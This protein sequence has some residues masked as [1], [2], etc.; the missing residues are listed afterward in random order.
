[1]LNT[2]SPQGCVLSPL[3][4]QLFTHDCSA[5]M[6]SSKLIKFADDITAIGMIINDDESD[7]R[8]EIELLVKWNNDN[9]IILNVDK[10]GELIADFRKCRNYKDSRIINGSAV[11]QANIHKFL[12]L[13]AM[14]TL[15]WTQNADKITKMGRQGLF[16][17]N[18]LKSYNIN[19]NVMINFYR[20]VI[21]GILTTNM[22]QV[23]KQ[24]RNQQQQ[25][26]HQNYRENHW[27]LPQ[28]NSIYL[29]G[30]YY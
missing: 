19:I 21:E 24:E 13:T 26:D 25:I 8:N 6:S 4:Y 28:Y 5:H 18:I 16:F 11:E 1:M 2:G 27:Y 20:A 23:H 30:T 15:S 7:Y 22:V 9:N 29:S 14:N 17:L 3:L 12:S 10:P